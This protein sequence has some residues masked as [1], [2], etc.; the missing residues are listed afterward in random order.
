MPALDRVWHRGAS[1]GSCG[2]ETT[3]LLLASKTIDKGLI[4]SLGVCRVIGGTLLLGRVTECEMN[5]ESGQ[6]Y[7][8]WS[9]S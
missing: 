7:T 8:P 2:L 9:Q 3:I 1:Q 4:S 5:V 6:F